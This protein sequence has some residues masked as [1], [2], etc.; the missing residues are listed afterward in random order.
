MKKKLHLLLTVLLMFILLLCGCTPSNILTS[1]DVSGKEHNSEKFQAFTRQLFIDSVST[2]ALTLHYELKNPS[3]YHITLDTI[4]LGRIDLDN[5][6]EADDSLKDAQKQLH[7]FDYDALTKDQQLT[8]DILDEYLQTELSIDSEELFYYPECLSSTSGIHSVLPILMSEYTFY[9]QEDIDIYLTLLEDIPAYFDNILAYEQAKSDTGLF[10]SDESVDEVI[11]ACREFINDPENNMLIEIFP[12][13]LNTIDGL[14]DTEIAD[15]TQC[16]KDAVLHSVIP[17]YESLIE[18]LEALKGTGQNENGLAYYDH[19][20]EYYEYLVKSKTGSDKTPD[21][22][23]AWLEETM[24]NDMMK[25]AFL[26]SADQSLY[27]RLNDTSIDLTEPDKMLETLQ[28]AL[29]DDFPKALTDNY[30][31]KYVHESLENSMNPAFYMIPPVDDPD[32][33]VIYLNNSQLSDNLSVFTTLAHEGYPGHL[34]QHAAF[35]ATDPDP[36]RQELSF[37]GYT[38][39]W[40]TYVE[41]M[42]YEW[43]GFDNGMSRCLQINQEVTLCL[44]ARTDLGVH[45]EG[46]TENDVASFLTDYGINDAETVHEVFRAIVTDPA[47]YLPYCIGYLE[48]QDL[49]ETTEEAM[50]DDFNLKDFYEFLLKLGPCQFKIIDKYLEKELIIP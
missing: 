12:K 50:G 21:E 34:Y 23:I 43:A 10:M 16:N 2:D 26:L 4:D 7:S 11:T 32:S 27:S 5:M 6:D 24:E 30:T 41:N 28:N 44:Y 49:R 45:Y 19:G 1:G 17:A 48:F 42:S 22:L 39:G 25:L 35:A 29:T 20:K 33:N 3:A 40:A 36:I 9:N 38:E 31:L 47:A 46:W 14:N 13:K 37:L 15:Y 8:Y 18:G